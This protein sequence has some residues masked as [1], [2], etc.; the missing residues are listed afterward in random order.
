M[1]ALKE[2]SYKRERLPLTTISYIHVW[3]HCSYV[4]LF[5]DT[6]I[7]LV[8]QA[9]TCPLARK[10]FLKW[11][12]RRRNFPCVLGHIYTEPKARMSRYSEALR[13]V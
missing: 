1:A 8:G 3:S 6:S 13:W 2:I 10:V 12:A 9:S 7:A 11:H 4:S 5:R